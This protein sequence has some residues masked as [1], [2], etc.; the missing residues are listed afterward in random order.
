VAALINFVLAVRAKIQRQEFVWDR[1]VVLSAAHK[2]PDG[3]Q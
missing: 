1:D 2:C 3:G